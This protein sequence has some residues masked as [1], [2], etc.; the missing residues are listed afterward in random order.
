MESLGLVDKTHTKANQERKR[1]DR[2]EVVLF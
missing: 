1:K 2:T